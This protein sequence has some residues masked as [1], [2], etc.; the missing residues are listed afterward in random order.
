MR[1]KVMAVQSGIDI[2][3]H[4]LERASL[5]GADVERAV[6]AMIRAKEIGGEEVAWEQVMSADVLERLRSTES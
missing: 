1:L 2:P 4:E 5:R 3:T 6:L